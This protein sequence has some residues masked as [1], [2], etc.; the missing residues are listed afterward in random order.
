MGRIYRE[1]DQVIVWLGVETELN[2]LFD[3]VMEGTLGMLPITQRVVGITY[4]KILEGS[5]QRLFWNKYW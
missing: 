3:M 5:L 1:A 2:T 4:G